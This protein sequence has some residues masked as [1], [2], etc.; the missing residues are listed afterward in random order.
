MT[1]ALRSLDQIAAMQDSLLA[2]S[3]EERFLLATIRRGVQGNRFCERD[4]SSEFDQLDWAEVLRI[5]FENRVASL[6]SYTLAPVFSSGRVPQKQL[7]ILKKFFLEMTQRNLRIKHSLKEVL[8]AFEKCDIDVIVYKGATLAFSIWPNIATRQMQDIDLVVDE[9]RSIEAANL[10]S[11]MGYLFSGDRDYDWYLNHTNEFPDFVNPVSGISIELHHRFF[12]PH[13][14]FNID[15]DAFWERSSISKIDG[16]PVR[17]LN[18]NQLLMLLCLHV[19][20]GHFLQ[21]NIRSLLDIALVTRKFKGAFDPGLW[22]KML[23]E[24]RLGPLLALPISISSREFGAD[25]GGLLKDPENALSLH[26]RGLSLKI[27]V[28]ASEHFLLKIRAQSTYEKVLRRIS[29]ELVYRPEFGLF[30]N[31]IC[32]FFPQPNYT[33][34]GVYLTFPKK[35][36]SFWIRLFRL[37]SG[38]RLFAPS[39]ESGN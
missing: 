39:K 33:L 4:L 3:A 30:R 18:P 35:F 15:E 10:L 9:S 26:Y 23:L 32:S 29:M 31:V 24:P 13:K 20:V 16:I 5:A 22:E 17:V 25:C 28:K 8:L 38:N 37:M 14:C 12:T 21:D 11:K 7:V 27:L 19:S 36:V 34:V 1:K 2:L 6:L